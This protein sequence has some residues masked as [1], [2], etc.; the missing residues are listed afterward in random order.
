MTIQSIIN[1]FILP[2]IG[3]KNNISFVEKKA[4]HRKPRLFLD[5]TELHFKD[6][7]TGVQR[8]TKNIASYFHAQIKIYDV[9]D[10]FAKKYGAG[11]YECGTNRAIKVSAGDVFFG[12]DLSIFLIPSNKKFLKKMKKI[13]IPVWFY[14][15][16]MIPI[17]FPET[18]D[19]GVRKHYPLWL[20]TI[21]NYS[22]IIGNSKSTIEDLINWIQNHYP[23][24]L[25]SLKF[26]YSY[27]GY[28]FDKNMNIQ[29]KTDSEQL[30]FLMVST[31]EPRKR[32]DLAVKAFEILWSEGV[33]ARLTLVGR[34]GWNNEKTFRLIRGS[35]NYGKNLI[36]Y[37][38]GISDE[39]LEELYGDSSALIFCSEAEG[40]GLPII[41]A[42]SHNLPL[43][44]RDIPVFREVAG[45]RAFYL[46]NKNDEAIFSEKIKEWIKL[47]ETNSIPLP[48][49]VTKNSWS[50]SAR[51][52]C[53]IM[54]VLI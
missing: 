7:K 3:I 13:G 2:L 46:E 30:S 39:Q 17:N 19:A 1:I 14:I 38:S 9:V 4:L 36:W 35:S 23:E 29:K 24:K 33:N 45:D 8:V 53:E 44:L 34:P 22:G 49:A 18:V 47:K 37:D 5:M 20:K 50:D 43:I 10:V 27:L 42:A 48:P 28:D 52:I 12:L 16:D 32:Y 41:E 6:S 25:N 11:F 26:G 40:F 15:H 21:I 54:G 51:K 31:V